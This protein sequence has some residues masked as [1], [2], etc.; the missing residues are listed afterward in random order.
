MRVSVPFMVLFS[1]LFSGKQ[2]N[3]EETVIYDTLEIGNISQIVS[4][5]GNSSLPILLFLHG[6]PGSSRMPQ[7]AIFSNLLKNHFMVVQWD[8]RETGK[9]LALN[10]TS[11]QITLDLME[12][13]TY[14]LI[15]ALLKKFGKEH[16]YLAGESW[17]TVLGFKMAEKHP[18]LLKAYLA[19]S[20]VIHQTESE[21]LLKDDLLSKATNI[22]DTNA[23]NELESI[24]I[25]FKSYM[26]IFYLRKWM[27]HDQGIIFNEQQTEA[28][29]EYL[30]NWSDT[31]LQTWNEAIQQNLS[32]S[33]TAIKCPVYFFIGGKDNQTNHQLATDYFDLLKA[34]EK[35]LYF[36]DTATHSVLTEE[37]EA[38]Q[39]VIIQDILQK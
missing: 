10:A 16:L 21:Q 32:K 22:N 38:V 25:P 19:F 39:K 33:L 15:T 13:D 24:S 4:Y 1:I 5:S 6:G 37:A 14:E 20:P 34:P 11:T 12:Q 9:T 31:W 26:D 7:S 23:I 27:F 35:K 18:E 3:A 36:Y 2:L 17:G 8:Q 30:Q 29:R 28:V